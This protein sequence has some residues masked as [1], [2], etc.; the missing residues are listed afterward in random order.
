MRREAGGRDISFDSWLNNLVFQNNLGR[1][2]IV[3]VVRLLSLAAVWIAAALGPPPAP[4]PAAAGN[5]PARALL[6]RFLVLRWS[7]VC[8]AHKSWRASCPK[9]T[10]TGSGDSCV[11]RL[12]WS[13]VLLLLLGPQLHIGVRA[14]RILNYEAPSRRLRQRR[15]APKGTGRGTGPKA[16]WTKA[17]EATVC[18][19]RSSSSSSS[20]RG[21]SCG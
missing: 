17:Q 3:V 12:S 1:W 15:Q 4:P 13:P 2:S 20:S 5:P 21:H 19:A 14:N 18:W 7:F 10:A 11:R 9:G 6:K 8:R 16:T